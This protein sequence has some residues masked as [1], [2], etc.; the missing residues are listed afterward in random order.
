LSPLSFMKSLSPLSNWS[1]WARRGR[2]R[3]R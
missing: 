3:C 1:P 2:C